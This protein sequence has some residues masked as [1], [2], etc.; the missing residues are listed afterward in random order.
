MSTHFQYRNVTLL[1]ICQSIFVCGQTTLFFVGGL[2][3]YKLALDKTLATLPVS[4]VIL[5]TAL[6]TIPA[7]LVMRRLGRR[8]GFM[9]AAMVGVCGLLTCAL[10]LFYSMF[11]L[12]C[13]GALTV[14]FYNAFC[15]YY[16]FAAADAATPLFRPKAISLV[17]AGGVVAGVIGPSLAVHSR[18]W[19]PDIEYLASYLLLATMTASVFMLVS[20]VRIPRQSAAELRQTGRPLLQIMRQP[21]FIAAAGSSMIGYGVMAFLMTATP[22]AMVSSHHPVSDAGLVIQWHVVGMFGPSFFTGHLINRFGLIKIMLSGAVLMLFAISAALSGVLVQHY[23]VAMFLVGLGWNF[24]FIGGST[25]L[26][27]VYTPAERAKTQAAHDFMVFATTASGSF[28][29]GQ[30]LFNFGWETVNLAALPLVIAVT[31]LITWYAFVRRN[32]AQALPL[33]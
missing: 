29:S 11:W 30:L 20:F 22:L 32:Q 3:G 15:Q 12:L 16:R 26:T 27:E 6:M 18:D 28:L 33:I 4:A 9:G 1:A 7:S 19:L 5:G 25:L 17:M 2:I 13:L 24:L 31:M 8:A 10:A 21:G 14:G 23:M